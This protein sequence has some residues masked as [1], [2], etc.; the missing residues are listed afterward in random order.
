VAPGGLS[1]IHR[2]SSDKKAA[3]STENGENFAKNDEKSLKN[4]K[5]SAEKAQ[6]PLKNGENHLKN[7]EKA[8]FFAEIGGQRFRR[9]WS[10]LHLSTEHLPQS[11]SDLNTHLS[12]EIWEMSP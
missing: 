2:L 12:L 4:G 9:V 5:N 11:F 6:N 7:G 3:I 10:G 8:Q 1:A